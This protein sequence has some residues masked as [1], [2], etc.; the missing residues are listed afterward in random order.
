MKVGL[1]GRWVVEVSVMWALNCQ[2]RELGFHTR[3]EKKI[4]KKKAA[5]MTTLEDKA[6]W[7][8][9][10]ADAMEDLGQEILKSSTDDIINRI[11]LL[12][13]DIKVR[14]G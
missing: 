13:N 14:M 6:I 2:S 8:S 5:K 11:K 10:E 3:Q 7:E 12:E 4:S 1:L 9:A